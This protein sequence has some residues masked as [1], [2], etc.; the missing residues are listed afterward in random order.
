MKKTTWVLLFLSMALVAATVLISQNQETRKGAYFAGANLSLLPTSF[1]GTVGGEVPVQVW[2]N[3]VGKVDFVQTRLCYDN[4]LNFDTS[5]ASDLISINTDRFSTVELAAVG[6]G[7]S[8]FAQCLDLAVSSNK[9]AASLATG[10]QRVATV[11][12]IAQASGSGSIA[13]VASKSQ[14]SG[15]NPNTGSND[16]S[17]SIDSVGQATYSVTGGTSVDVGTGSVAHFKMSYLGLLPSASCAVNWNLQLIALGNGVTKTYTGLTPSGSQVSNGKVIYEFT[18]TLSGFTQTSNVALFLRGPKQLQIKYGVQNQGAMYNKAGGE[19]TLTADASTTT[20]YNFS[21]YPVLSGD[22]NQDGVINGQDFSLT[23]AGALTHRQV[24]SG[25]SLDIDL[26]GDC[27]ATNND[28]Q[29]LKTS[30]LEKQ[31]QLY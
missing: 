4:K 10:A 2:I 15:S 11:K 5:R 18:K 3:T 23:K 28:V 6:T 1:S 17:L 13:M 31:G 30:L 19:L 25:S 26:D 22:I 21:G 29:I 12:F 27:M 14:V 24:S 8:G 7:E 16:M 9:A 20:L